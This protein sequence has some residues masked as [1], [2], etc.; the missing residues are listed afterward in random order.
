MIETEDILT[1]SPDLLIGT[2]DAITGEL[3]D[4]ELDDVLG[5]SDDFPHELTLEVTPQLSFKDI[6]TI[7]VLE[8]SPVF[9]AAPEYVVEIAE[10]AHAAVYAGTALALVPQRR[11]ASTESPSEVQA[12]TIPS[13]KEK[14]VVFSLG[15]I[16]YAVPMAQVL[17]VRELEHFTP[18][19][20]VPTW[21]LGITNL[22]G[23][24]VSVVDLQKLAGGT[25][26]RSTAPAQNLIV[27]QTLQG[28]LT[29]CLAVESIAGL[30]HAS[31]TE[32]QAVDRVFGDGLTPYTQGVVTQGEEL[33]SVLNLESLLHSLEITQ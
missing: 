18:V 1:L 6:P 13:V 3:V 17:E 23:D 22:R 2:G 16:K 19:M 20:N 24:I 27:V 10:P 15:S 33:L 32:I 9:A 4:L 26:A 28:E 8:A 29:T 5:L 7:Q 12:D 25:E 31:A 11:S 21:V 30:V 14:H